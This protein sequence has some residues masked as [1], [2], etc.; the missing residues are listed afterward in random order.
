M[1][2]GAAPAHAHALKPPRSEARLS[3]T[4]ARDL[5]K[6]LSDGAFGP[7]LPT[8]ERASLEPRAQRSRDDRGQR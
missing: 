1:G 4:I 2:R 7:L 6:A 5:Q 8:A 3:A